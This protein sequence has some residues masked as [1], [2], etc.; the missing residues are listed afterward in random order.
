MSDLT[1]ERRFPASQEV[2][3]AFVTRPENVLQWFGHDGW[4]AIDQKLDFTRPGP[5]HSKVNSDEGNLFHLSGEVIEVSSPD[6]VRFTWAWHDADGARGHE[7][8]VEFELRADGPDA[9]VFRLHHTGLPNDEVATRH[10]A[11]W[12]GPLAR[13]ARY[14]PLSK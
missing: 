5:W 11:G 9:C 2:V 3:F 1:L 14:L 10:K 6:R 7:S 8:Q 4:I 12:A 13:L